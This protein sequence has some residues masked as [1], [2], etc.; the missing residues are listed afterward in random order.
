VAPLLLWLPSL[1]LAY[2]IHSFGINVPIHDDW[3]LVE[4]AASRPFSSWSSLTGQHNEHLI[5][6]P[7]LLMLGVAALTRHSTV[8]MVFTSWLLLCLTGAILLRRHQRRST[9]PGAA[10]R[11]LMLVP[12]S[13][14]LFDLALGARRLVAVLLVAGVAHA[15][16]A[17]W[18]HG[19]TDRRWRSHSASILADYRLQRDEVLAAFLHR[20]VAMVRRLATFLESNHLS[21]FAAPDRQGDR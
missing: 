5:F 2:F 8:A 6:F 7:R 11:L 12:I 1:T 13:F 21:V 14:L 15:S 10:P 17:G 20:D 3:T 19:V 18:K 9:G 16:V 4:A